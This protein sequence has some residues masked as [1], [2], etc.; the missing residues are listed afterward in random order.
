[1]KPFFLSIYSGSRSQLLTLPAIPAL[2]S[3]L[4]RNAQE[5]TGVRQS[6]PQIS[7]A[8][9]N[10]IDE[11]L[12]AAYK[13]F[14]AGPSK[15]TEALQLFTT[16]LH[17]LLFVIVDSKKEIAEVKELIG[18]CREY[19]LGLKL[20]LL[21]K[22]VTDPVRQLELAAYFTHCNIQQVHLLLSLRSAMSVAYKVK[23]FLSASSF[24][25]RLLEFDPAKEVADQA[26]KVVKLC[27]QTPEN[28]HKINY[29]ERNPFF[30]C[31]YSF[32]P[33]YKGNTSTQCPYCS[34]HYLPEH[35]DKLCNICGIAQIGKAAGGLQLVHERVR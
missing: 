22:D 29:D 10:I 34:T 11:N 23:N 33:I 2:S 27:E 24:A 28:A 9:Q 17:S 4:Y 18:L 31:G 12:K 3:P 20:E 26:R 21:R 16:I 32:S 8:L 7:V 6:L 25:R 30:I 19:T 35:K 15:F 13:S 1:L 5:I 14:T